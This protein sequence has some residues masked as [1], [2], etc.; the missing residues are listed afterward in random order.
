MTTDQKEKEEEEK[1]GEKVQQIECK[2]EI[3][4]RK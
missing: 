4:V 3:K 2:L 1:D